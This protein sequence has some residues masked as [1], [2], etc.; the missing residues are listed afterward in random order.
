MKRLVRLKQADLDVDQVLAY[1]A[2]EAPHMELAFLDALEKAYSHIQRHPSTGSLRY[3]HAL[4]IPGLRFWL[5]TRFPQVVFYIEREHHI[6]LIRVLH[7]GRD[8]PAT[9]Q[10]N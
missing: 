7:G 10:D 6:A 9:L 5:C 4:D 2:A 1:H 8:I 3:A